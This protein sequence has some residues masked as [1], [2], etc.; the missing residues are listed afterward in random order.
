MVSIVEGLELGFS[1][2]VQSVVGFTPKIIAAFIV[3]IIGLLVGKLIGR[4]VASILEALKINKVI[5]D[6]PIGEW[7][8]S[9]GMNVLDFLDALAR[10]FIYLIFIM[11]AVNILDIELFSEFLQRTVDYLP[12]FF[13]GI[14]IL[15][16]GLTV[17]D[18]LLNWV[19]NVERTMKLKEQEVIETGIRFFL[20]LVI[21][22]M[23]LNQMRVDTSIVFLFLRPLAWALAIVIIFKWGVKDALVEYGKVKKK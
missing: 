17:A 20:F 4:V 18:V 16:V 2:A 11:A 22:I 13:A 5:K 9:T 23:A 19:K 10:W 21:T 8:L 14:V 6:T 15:I 1:N 12:N 7:I 3:L